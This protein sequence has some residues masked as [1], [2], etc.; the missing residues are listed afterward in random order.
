MHPRVQHAEKPDASR[1]RHRVRRQHG[2][3]DSEKT[4]ADVV[5]SY[6]C[7]ARAE[8]VEK[9]RA[10]RA[11]SDARIV[12]EHAE[13]GEDLDDDRRITRRRQARVQLHGHGDHR[14][15]LRGESHAQLAERAQLDTLEGQL[16][17]RETEARAAIHL[18]AAARDAREKHAADEA[19][20][21]AA[22]ER[23]ATARRAAAY[24]QRRCS[25]NI[26]RAARARFFL[27]KWAA[28]EA[29]G[30]DVGAE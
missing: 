6:V 1:A 4:F 11:V 3:Q 29:G 15:N 5:I 12:R 23:I 26:C 28:P 17:A 14:P 2:I 19:R 10:P 9:L 13:I 20:H 18:A 25:E 16:R 8:C 21:L 24:A 27:E 22:L 7:H 30:L